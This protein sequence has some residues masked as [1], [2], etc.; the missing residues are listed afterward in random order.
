MYS[1]MLDFSIEKNKYT[2][3]DFVEK[4]FNKKDDVVKKSVKKNKKYDVVTEVDTEVDTEDTEVDKLTLSDI[5][6]NEN[7]ENTFKIYG[8]YRKI[9]V[10]RVDKWGHAY[11]KKDGVFRIVVDERDKRDSSDARKKITGLAASS[12][13]IE[14][15][16][17]IIKLLEKNDKVWDNIKINLDLTSVKKLKKEDYA[18]MIET[19]LE[20][21]NRILK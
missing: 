14:D 8:T 12:H 7:I 10:P 17:K 5:K 19:F 9:K 2:L 16:I 11:G 6:Y 15:L 18:K 1:K 3:N 20:N 4:I 21:N 13:K